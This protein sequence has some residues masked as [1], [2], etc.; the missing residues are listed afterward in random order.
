MKR[1]G[2]TSSQGFHGRRLTFSI[3]EGSLP[4]VN[5]HVSGT[6]PPIA[7]RVAARG[8]ELTERVFNARHRIEILEM[9]RKRRWLQGII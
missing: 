5:S 7:C 2:P 6:R 1:T 9:L 4:D 8:V 3:A